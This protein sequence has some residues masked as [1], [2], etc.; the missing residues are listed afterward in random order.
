[1]PRNSAISA[2]H[3]SVPG[4]ARLRV[5][6]L[7]GHPEIKTA[8]ESGLAGKPGIHGA[9]ANVLTGNVLVFYDG[10][11]TL[12]E[13]IGL[14][15]IVMTDA[16]PA[17]APPPGPLP[18]PAPAASGRPSILEFF[19]AL[20]RR[21][22]AP[23]SSP[24]VPAQAPPPAEPDVPWHRTDANAVVRFWRSS[25]AEGLRSADAAG[26][27]AI[28]GA[29]AI[30]RT[31]MRSAAA[32]LLGQF[33]SLP[34]LM[35]AGSAAISAATGGIADAIV[36][37]AVVILN[38]AIGAATEFQAEKT[39]SSLM[40]LG[41]PIATV[42]RDGEVREVA[43]E[44]LVPGDIL[45][46]RR[47][48]N[49]PAD[50][51][52]LEAED[53]TV[54]ESALTGE[55]MAVEKT[56]ALLPRE[57]APLAERFNMIYRGTVI[58]GGS[59][60]A[61]VVATGGRTQIGRIQALIASSEQPRTP[62]E[63]QVRALG[64]QL[65]WLTA[66]IAA[67][68]LC[69]GL[70]RGYSLAE[71]VRNAIA[72]AVAAVPEGLPVVATVAL[73]GGVG[74]LARHGVLV[75]RLEAVETLGTVEVLCFD[76]TGTLTLNQMS[77][78]A[79]YAGMKHYEV[80][81]GTFSSDRR[82]VHLSQ[83]P[84]IL[85]LL[86]ACSLCSEA[87][88]ET[89]NGST[90][91]N[92]SATEAALVRMALNS[93]IDVAALRARYPLLRMSYRTETQNYM[94]TVHQ[95]GPGRELVAVKGSPIE[96]LAL[97]RSYAKGGQIL[98]LA[99]SERRQIQAENDRMAGTALRVLGVAMQTPEDSGLV[100]LG[101]AGIADPPRQGLREL[102]SDFHRAGIRPVMVT[103]DQRA[104]ARAI[105]RAVALNNGDRLEVLDW[106]DVEGESPAVI[107]ERVSRA[108]IFAR[109]SP[110]EKLQIV[111]AFQQ[112]HR[113]VAMT[114]DGI[115]D[116]PALKAA[117][118]GV[119]LGQSGA[120]VAREVADVL[121]TEDNIHALVPAIAEG[122]RVHANLRKSIHYI[123]ATNM[124][125]V[126]LVLGS[127]AAGLGQPLNARQLL[128]INLITDVF[129]EL[130]LALAPAEPGLME[131]GPADPRAA[132]IGAP[133]M[134]RLWMQSAVM[135]S[136]ALGGYVYGLA[137][138]GGGPRASAM[139][140]LTLTAAQLLHA[141][142]PRAAAPDKYLSMSVL[143]GFGA[144]ALSQFGFAGLLG[145][146][147]IG[148]PDVFVCALA[149]LASFLVN[150][151]IGRAPDIVARPVPAAP[152]LLPAPRTA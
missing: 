147:R 24:P 81:G 86:E 30:A 95:A 60:L 146:A 150:A 9:S 127:L 38:A 78:V 148:L 59:G 15:E 84:E 14:I 41:E 152:A 106:N 25:R 136:A 55:S 37:S 21:T 53:L 47:G 97:S 77:V 74:A 29:N 90:A 96:V 35:L 117:D 105:G 61:V 57:E 135:T 88:L 124:G 27:L 87:E 12:P 34:V 17:E 107:A 66:G 104:T 130:A 33:N 23:D 3:T 70:L 94:T 46:L 145:T 132:V 67:A 125:E 44:E 98:P 48:V 126:L 108:H 8:L 131:R 64:G 42:V 5:A 116:G 99:D 83:N 65:V 68:A 91:V 63:A 1:M 121:L 128:W 100:W 18:A 49:V 112:G 69:I 114:G 137:R 28:Y 80:S 140:F 93:G 13:V 134:R 89:A 75:R 151:W 109:V 31:P 71:M 115:N 20:W 22:P 16:G 19:K 133:E 76:K 85:K 139:A 143:A 144:L 102:L 72:L 113:V 40:N 79:A 52:V 6:A 4:R 142:P 39:I 56:A 11:R 62:L 36:I 43:G 50:A 51:R 82:P 2:I 10:A 120:R 111:R 141:L 123:A 7:R 58:T 32:I 110:A 92:G 149:S 129:P 118:V 26:R 45:V 119:A 54:D 103:G 73:A 101:L 138:Y 122:R